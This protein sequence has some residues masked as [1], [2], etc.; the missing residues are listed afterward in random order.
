MK[1]LLV[2]VMALCMLVPFA[3]LAQAQAAPVIAPV[4]MTEAEMAQV[5]GEIIF[6]TIAI[7]AGKVILKKTMTNV[8]AGKAGAAGPRVLAETV[9]NTKALENVGRLADGARSLWSRWRS[10]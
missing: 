5:E 4:P 6:T 10:R 1:K 7:I 9:G 2:M 8:A 3:S